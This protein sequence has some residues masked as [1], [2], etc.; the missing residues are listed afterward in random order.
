MTQ[1]SAI[2][3]LGNQKPEHFLRDVACGI[4][5]LVSNIR[6][7]DAAARRAFN[8]GDEPTASLLGSFADEEAAKVLILIDAVRCPRSEARA[9][10]RTLKRWR[11]HLWKGIYLRAC[12]WR[13]VNLSE[14]AS[15]IELEMQPFYLDGPHDVDWI[16][17]NEITRERE[18]QI[19]VDL[20][21]DITEPGQAG[22]ERFWT[23]PQDFT[24][25][26]SR[27]RTSTCVE[28]TLALHAHGIAAAEGLEHVAAIW[29]PVDPE[30]IDISDLFAKINETL[31][32]VRLDSEAMAVEETNL[33]SPNSLAYWPFPLWS[34]AEPARV[35]RSEFLDALREDRDAELKRINELQRMKEPP[36]DISRE[37][38]LEMHAAFAKVAEERGK[39]IDAHLAGKSGPPIIT[40]DA[41]L[42]VSRTYAWMELKGLW[43]DLTDGERVSLVALAWFTRDTIAN[44][45]RAVRLARKKSDI[46]SAEAEHYCLWLGR[47]WLKGLDRWEAP[48]GHV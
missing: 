7:L 41:D 30:S 22:Q 8:D 39:R 46:H 2:T 6:R 9:R 14:A 36:P 11:S 34:V 1:S 4:D 23:T 38:V 47:D 18:R 25:S 43:W 44:W 27:Y 17:P 24:A 26:T 15:Y 5:H 13:P 37:K 45:P 33:P 20:V 42:D 32:A 31:S 40:A 35:K 10:A 12:D 16:F 3:N 48:P 21:E 28:V 29:Q 19:Y